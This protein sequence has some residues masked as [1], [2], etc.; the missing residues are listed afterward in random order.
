MEKL[1]NEFRK[2]KPAPAIFVFQHIPGSSQDG[3]GKSYG[4]LQS[5]WQYR[6]NLDYYNRA[7]LKKRKEMNFYIVPAYMNIDTENNYPE[8][9]QEVNGG[10]PQTISRQSNGVHP[11]PAGYYQIGDTLYCILKAFLAGK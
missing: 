7:L 8:E 1:V 5:S 2:L 9:I 11:A 3:F 4:C 10:N 6:K